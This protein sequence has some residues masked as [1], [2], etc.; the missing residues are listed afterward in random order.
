MKTRMTAPN[1]QQMQSRKARLK[2]SV[3]RRLLAIDMSERRGGRVRVQS[4]ARPP[5]A[6]LQCAKSTS[7]EASPQRIVR[8]SPDSTDVRVLAA[9]PPEVRTDGSTNQSRPP[10]RTRGTA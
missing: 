6:E 3:S 4:W 8:R 10:S 1:P 7:A 9:F 5:L 2:T